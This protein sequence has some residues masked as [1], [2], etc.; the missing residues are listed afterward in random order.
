VNL[1]NCGLIKKKP[2]NIVP[3]STPYRKGEMMGSKM[4]EVFELPLSLKYNETYE[5]IVDEIVNKS[6][7][8]FFTWGLFQ[9][10]WAEPVVRAINEY[11]TQ[12]Q[13]IADLK[14]QLEETEGRLK[15]IREIRL[16]ANTKGA[17]MYALAQAQSIAGRR[18]GG[19]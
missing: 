3:S 9:R 1:S 5:D 4:S 8:T 18:D 15:E 16:S 17:Y 11:D 7:K 2:K 14:R 10:H 6:G 13:T 12:A 19:E